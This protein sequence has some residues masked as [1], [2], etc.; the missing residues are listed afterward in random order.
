MI[1]KIKNNVESHL[2]NC[3]GLN[4][5]DSWRGE[6]K[7]IFL[8]LGKL[9]NHQNAGQ[10]ISK[11]KGEVTLMFDCRWRLEKLNSILVGSLNDIIEIEKHIKSLINKKVEDISFIGRIPEMVIK[12]EN[13]IWLQ[14]FT[15]YKNEDWAIIFLNSGSICRNKRKIVFEKS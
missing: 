3:I 8:E 12:F 15:S 7:T 1:Q 9:Q 5:S 14:S 10:Y 6:G 13:N 11:G 4:V 2:E